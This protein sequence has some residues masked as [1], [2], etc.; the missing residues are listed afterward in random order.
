MNGHVDAN[1]PR[2]LRPCAGSMLQLFQDW[3]R[4]RASHADNDSWLSCNRG[5]A[6]AASF[7]CLACPLVCGREG[8]SASVYI[9]HGG[10]IM[11]HRRRY[12]ISY[13]MSYARCHLIC[14][15]RSHLRTQRGRHLS[16]HRIQHLR[17]H[18]M[19]HFR[20]HH[21]TSSVMGVVES[22]ASRIIACAI[23]EA[24]PSHTSSRSLSTG[25]SR[26]VYNVPFQKPCHV[27]S[28]TSC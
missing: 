23:S 6:V 19:S 7:M 25:A 5:C 21:R 1:I 27:T 17:A 9:F 24:T 13:A 28:Q 10:H 4:T 8:A 3:L 11:S 20:R 15:V 16:T 2:H 22:I 26:L 18:H 12:D 14:N